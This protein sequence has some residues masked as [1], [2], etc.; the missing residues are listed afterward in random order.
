MDIFELH[1]LSLSCV[2]AHMT[3]TMTVLGDELGGWPHTTSMLMLR[4]TTTAGHGHF[5]VIYYLLL[6]NVPRQLL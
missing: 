1:T 5:P 6:W 3:T 2:R 4:M